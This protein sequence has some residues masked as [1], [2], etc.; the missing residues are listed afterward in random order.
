MND[1]EDET[2]G[3]GGG[4]GYEPVSLTFIG[5]GPAAS[6]YAVEAGGDGGT[7]TY[8][9]GGGAD[10]R[11]AGTGIAGETGTYALGGGADARPAGTGVAGGTGTRATYANHHRA[12]LEPERGG[13]RPRAA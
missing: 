12:A 2:A 8:A 11:P 9:L 10:A 7:S 13:R 6:A 5:L 3:D 1:V 4:G